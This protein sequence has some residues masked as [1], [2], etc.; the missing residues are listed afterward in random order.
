MEIEY[1]SSLKRPGDT[2]ELYKAL[3][4][5]MLDGYTDEDIRKANESF[6]SVYAYDGDTLV[7]LGRVAS[8]GLIAAVMSGICVRTD[9]RR[10]GIGAE[11]VK[12]IVDYCQSGI[13]SLN[14]QIFCEDSLIKWYEGMGFEKMAVGMR[15]QMPIREE[16]CA[17]KKNFS[18]VYGIEQ[19]AE[20]SEEFYWY[21]FDAFG[22]FSYYGGIGSE[23]VKVPFIRMNLY[24]REPVKFCAEMIFE[25]V[26]EFEIGC[27]GV[28]TPLFGFDI[29]NTEK[30]GYAEKKRYKVRSLEDDDISF[31]CEKFRVMS[32]TDLSKATSVISGAYSPINKISSVPPE[33]DEGTLSNDENADVN[34]ENDITDNSSYSEYSESGYDSGDDDDGLTDESGGFSGF[35]DFYYSPEEDDG[36]EDNAPA[37]ESASEIA[38]PADTGFGEERRDLSGRLKE[39]MDT[40]ADVDNLLKQLDEIN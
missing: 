29:V 1:L 9:Y 18:E 40:A 27:L 37:Y 39:L 35:A 31:F 30:L 12:R 25:N 13:Y 14:V 19:I 24:C 34:G 2:V 22:D 26:S 6:Y 10:H 20:L 16:H 3:E 32:V 36:A 21:D 8:D 23:G 11:I 4:W 7:G 33:D 28:R 38:A 17:L 15:K 5:Y